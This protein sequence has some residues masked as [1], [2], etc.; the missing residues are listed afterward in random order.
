MGS[1]G[2]RIRGRRKGM[3]NS[4]RPREPSLGEPVRARASD[5]SLSVALENHLNPSS[6]YFGP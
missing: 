2:L 3:R 5:T 4:D 1:E 6:R